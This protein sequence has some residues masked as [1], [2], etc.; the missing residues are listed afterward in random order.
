MRGICSH[1]IW[2][3]CTLLLLAIAT[4]LLAADHDRWYA[5]QMQGQR[6]GWMHTSQRTAGDRIT[7]TSEMHMKIRRGAVTVDISISSEFVE[8]V[9]GK[10]VSGKSS[11]T[12]ASMPNVTEYI[13]KDGQVEV[14]TGSGATK[15]MAVQPLPE[16]A[17]LTPAASAMFVSKRLEAGAEDIVVRTLD[18]TTGLTAVTSTYKVLER[19]TVE[20]LG[21]VVPAI[22]WSATSDIQPDIETVGFVDERGVPIRTEIDMGGIKMVIVLADRELAKLDIDA[23]ELMNSTFVEPKGKIQEPRKL[24]RASYLLS[25]P[26]G[27]IG[28]LPSA[29][30]QIVTRVNERTLR[31]VVDL[32]AKTA[33][34]PEDGG[35]L[36]YRRPSQMI[37][38]ED[39]VV[40]RLTKDA[41]AGINESDH[42]ARAEAL[43]NA[44][45]KHIKDKSF[46]VGFASAAEVARTC[47][48][49]CS[50][51]AALLTA[52]LRNAGYASRTASGLVFV[53]QFAGRQ[54]IFGYHMW[55]QVLLE[56][57]G[58]QRWIDL[59]A[60]M[61][62]GRDFD[63]GG[64]DA[65]HITI[66]VASLADGE[67][68]NGLVTL[69]PLL[70]RLEITVE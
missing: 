39:E 24:R 8:T 32:D 47:T 70:G 57:D 56:I 21:K 59:D 16:G 19:T 67:S 53:D 31:V 66:A 42:A 38:S 33:A 1:W 40:A 48:G 62:A 18:T 4:P 61:P 29:G 58:T 37:N 10:P 51:H 13:F 64:F 14:H 9:D 35:K 23:P 45:F 30:P 44:V 15:S 2:P 65:T 69:A 49:D 46:G 3:L 22:K 11:M 54:G 36:E 28:D 60:T 41:L 6:A 25:V 43:R 52:M 63:A 26:D 7:S 17:W 5:L 50:E 34:D 55:S 12:M 27:R 68:I 20:A